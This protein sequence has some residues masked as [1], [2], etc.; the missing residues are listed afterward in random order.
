MRTVRIGGFVLHEFAKALDVVFRLRSGGKG[1]EIDTT[2]GADDAR[3]SLDEFDVGGRGLELVGGQLLQLLGQIVA[4]AGR[5]N[6]A[7][8]DGARA[9]RATALFQFVAVALA[10]LDLVD[11]EAELVGDELRIGGGMALPVGLGADIESRPC[12][13]SAVSDAPASEPA[14]A[15]A[16]I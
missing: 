6:A 9:A 8:R 14:K 11:A 10:Y 13:P 16:S 12:R 4:G 5:R 3:G 2:V 15:Q 7:Q 1:R